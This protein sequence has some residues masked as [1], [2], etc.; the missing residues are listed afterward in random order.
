MLA[1][2]CKH[3]YTT[4]QYVLVYGCRMLDADG[5]DQ[6]GTEQPDMSRDIALRVYEAMAKTQI[7]DDI[8][9]QSQRQ[10]RFSFYLTS[11]GEEAATVGSAAALAS[12]DEVFA[13]YREQGV[14]MYRGFSFQKFADQLYGNMFESG[15]GRQMPIHYGS[16][17][18][19]F[20][21]ISSPLATQML[22]ACGAAYA[23]KMEQSTSISACYFG[24]GA[25]SEGDAAAALNFAAVLGVP[26]LFICRNNGYAISTP[27]H[28]QYKGDGVCARAFANGMIAIRV[29]GGDAR[30][31]YHACSYA[32]EKAIEGCQPILVECLSYRSG[33]H[34]TSDDSSRYRSNFEALSYPCPVRR[35]GHW[36]QSKGWWSDEEEEALRKHTRKQ[37]SQALSEAAS[38]PKPDLS[39]LF[40]DV[41][42]QVTP[43]LQEQMAETL[44]FV[45]KHPGMVPPGVPINPPFLR[46][47]DDS[48]LVNWSNGDQD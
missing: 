11:A 12:T 9:Y 37:I 36:I 27:I 38:Q 10:G 6:G 14:L 22:H 7:M 43:N 25:A 34:S 32:R 18:L 30:A 45:A 8:C 21:T 5:N 16:S 39:N 3:G 17:D 23:L 19:H 35:F 31:V 20:Q 28:E 2:A 42:A 29:D 40:T 46:G 1:H 48:Q 26:C 15:K 41:Y 33:H 13:Q 4:L 24:E 44:Q 47:M